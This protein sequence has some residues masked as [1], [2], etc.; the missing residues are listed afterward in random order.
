M[1]ITTNQDFKSKLLK[2]K[3]FDPEQTYESL[4][5]ES[6]ISSVN[7]EL[8]FLNSEAYHQIRKQI[9]GYIASKVMNDICCAN[10]CISKKEVSDKPL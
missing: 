6:L 1:N 10:D 7:I 4:N 3:A 8:E 2:S 5:Q 9:I